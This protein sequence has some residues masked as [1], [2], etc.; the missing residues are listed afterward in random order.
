MTNEKFKSEIDSL[1]KLFSIYCKDKHKN[2]TK[3]I[4]DIRYKDVIYHF[5][6]DL[7]EECQELINYSISKLQ[8]CTHEIKPRC[9]KCTKPCYDKTT[10]KK[11]A[12]IM[13][14][15]GIR[16]GLNKIKKVLTQ[17]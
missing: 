12:K 9:R 3:N 13:R 16:L 6:S 7:C 8:T 1:N 15:A 2:Q 14:Y 17:N 4:Q 11:V 5:Q 10:W